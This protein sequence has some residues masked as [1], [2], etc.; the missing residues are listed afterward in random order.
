M[1]HPFLQRLIL[2][3]DT[4]LITLHLQLHTNP[5]YR[6]ANPEP[7]DEALA[8]GKSSFALAI[9]G[10]IAKPLRTVAAVG[11]IG[12]AYAS[13]RLGAEIKAGWPIVMSRKAPWMAFLRPSVGYV[14]R[15]LLSEMTRLSPN[16]KVAMS[17][18]SFAAEHSGFTKLSHEERVSLHPS[19]IGTPAPA[20]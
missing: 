6:D 8:S 19:P 13:Y 1:I 5:R 20:S 10:L 2:I 11:T 3:P 7:G 12:G 4:F 17:P 9:D 16:D 18:K 15:E 14:K